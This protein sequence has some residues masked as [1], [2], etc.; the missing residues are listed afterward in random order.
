MRQA[1]SFCCMVL[2]LCMVSCGS[3]Q[4]ATVTHPSTAPTATVPPKPPQTALTY[5]AIG[6]SDAF[7]IGTSDPPT[8][9]WPTVLTG[10]LKS[11]V[12]LVNLGIP[13]ATTDLA[14][15][16]ELPVAVDA[17][18]SLVTI[19]L[20]VNDLDSGVS[21]DTY[22]QRLGAILVALRD[23]T[24]ATI[25]VANFPDLTLLPSFAQDDPGALRAEIELWNAGIAA[26]CASQNVTLVDLYASWT[27]LSTHPEYISK[28]GLHPS[29]LG[30]A[31]LAT[32][33]AN[34]ILAVLPVSNGGTA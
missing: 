33:F 2:A 1:I 13:G 22:L 9:N 23:R 32:L 17:Q 18:P 14:A 19:W 15:R 21:L 24:R 4:Q 12:H 27:D 29:T 30:A 26:L 10:K 3:S 6:A 31:R 16:D 20:G 8:Q 28:D 25:F 34:V 7:G 5:V 11:V